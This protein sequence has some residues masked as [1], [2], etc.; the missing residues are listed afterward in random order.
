MIRKLI[1]KN[2]C[3]FKNYVNLQNDAFASNPASKIAAK[4]SGLAGNGSITGTF[5]SLLQVL[6][7]NSVI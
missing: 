6:D 7:K 1:M 3:K 5:R 2:S 4:L